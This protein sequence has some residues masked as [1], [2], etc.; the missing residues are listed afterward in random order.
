MCGYKEFR[1][2]SL[3][4]TSLANT[5]IIHLSVCLQYEMEDFFLKHSI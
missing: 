1:G 4:T 3:V 2:E 5:E